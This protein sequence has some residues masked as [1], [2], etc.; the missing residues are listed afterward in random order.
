M[1]TIK[2]AIADDHKLF[3]QGIRMMLETNSDFELVTEVGDG[4]ELLKRMPIDKPDVILLDVEMPNLNGAKALSKLKGKHPDVRVIM[5]TMH[6]HEEHMIHFLA[7]GAGAY[8]LKD[9]T[10]EEMCK[11][12]RV[13]A[14]E[15]QYLTP[16]SS[17]ALLHQLHPDES[18]PPEFSER[19]KEVLKLICEEKTSSEIADILFLSP[20]TVETYRKQLLEKTY[21]KN[22]AGLVKYAMQRKGIW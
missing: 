21:S 7:N 3:R 8:L 10:S 18:T 2:I 16:E 1:E 15:G 17:K 9:T 5:L 14:K 4:N 20:R 13:V 12:I 19:E 22:T 6:A 11:A